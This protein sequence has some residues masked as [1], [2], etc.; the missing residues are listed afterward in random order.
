MKF[1][2]EITMDNAAFDPDPLVELS[3]LL[4]NASG[5]FYQLQGYD[6]LG[7]DLKEGIFRDYNGAKVG[8]YKIEGENE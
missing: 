4:G 6:P 3:R 8:S 5:T 7:W 2:C 1:T